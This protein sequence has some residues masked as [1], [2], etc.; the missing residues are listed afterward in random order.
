MQGYFLGAVALSFFLLC[1]DA[2]GIVSLP[3]FVETVLKWVFGLSLVVGAVIF[4]GPFLQRIFV[5]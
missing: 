3:G 2:V 5:R 4:G 1:L